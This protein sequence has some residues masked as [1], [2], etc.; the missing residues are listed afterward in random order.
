MH[1]RSSELH[2]RPMPRDPATRRPVLR[3]SVLAACMMSAALWAGTASA[4]L[5]GDDEARRAILDVRAKVTEQQAQIDAISKRL[6]DLAARAEPA[7]RAQLDA[8]NQLEALRQEI[9]R[10]RGQLE[11]QGNDLA[12][13]Q[14]RERDLYGDLDARIK[15]FEPQAVQVDG[16]TVAVDPAERKAYD[17]ALAQFRGGEFRGAQ[18]SFQQFLRDHPD[19]PYAANSMFWLGSAQFA[20]KDY[21]GAMSTH[22]SLL[23]KYPDNP[24]AAD[25]TLNLAYAQIESG[26]R[27]TAR[28]TLE[29]VISRYP[30]T[31]AAQAAKDR[32]SSLKAG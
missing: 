5:F 23:N 18:T 15:K 3:P 28:R 9:A 19:S 14:R 7:V 1:V 32:L 22:Q 27:K 20:L 12:N 29:T 26:D 4:A 6:D 16:Q 25:A 11:V 30:S 24:R 13:A 17:E 2:S 10:L 31:P 8:Q 21:R